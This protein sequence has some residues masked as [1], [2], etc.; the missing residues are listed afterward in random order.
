MQDRDANEVVERTR[1]RWPVNEK[2]I[3]YEGE[4]MPY[5]KA[6]TLE[7]TRQ[8]RLYPDYRSP[9]IL[10]RNRGDL[11]FEEKT[12]EW[13]GGNAAIRHG[14][15]LADLDNDGDMD[16]VVNTLNSP[17]EI[18]INNASGKRVAV[19]LKGRAPNTD[20]IGARVSLYGGATP[21]QIEEITAGGHYLSSSQRRIVFAASDQAM[22]LE[23]LWR[24]G[25]RSTVPGARAGY[26]YVVTEP[27]L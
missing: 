7:R 26:L 11:K 4:L 15:V 9:L 1:R 8:L 6:F 12:G 27:G 21:Q 22:R 25:S 3:Q 20:A 10:L 17:A 2:N 13:G 14:M 18:W 24:G 19:E 5:E 23:V 16:L